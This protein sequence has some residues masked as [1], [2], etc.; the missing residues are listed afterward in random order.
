MTISIERELVNWPKNQRRVVTVDGKRHVFCGWC[1]GYRWLRTLDPQ[2][3][4]AIEQT[5]D[6]C[7]RCGLV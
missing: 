5:A 2:R 6:A 4:G 1:G 7:E 3:I